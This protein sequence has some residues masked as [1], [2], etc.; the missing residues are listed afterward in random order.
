MATPVPNRKPD[1]AG[2]RR[3]RLPPGRWSRPGP[4][5]AG[6]RPDV[7]ADLHA[8]V[9]SR[10][11]EIDRY[12]DQDEER[13]LAAAVRASYD[14]YKAEWDRLPAGGPARREAAAPLADRLT[15]ETVA[16]CQKL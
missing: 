14:A 3:P 5:R 10:L 11:A 12:A 4:G 15:G 6:V 8:R 9:L 13:V 16:R 2:G 7:A 1:S